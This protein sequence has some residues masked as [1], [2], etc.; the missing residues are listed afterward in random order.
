MPQLMPGA[1]LVPGLDEGALDDLA[2]QIAVADHTRD[3]VVQAVE[4]LLVQASERSSPSSGCRVHLVVRSTLFNISRRECQAAASVAY[5]DPRRE[6]L[7]SPSERWRPRRGRPRNGRP[8][9]R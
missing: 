3:E 1:K 7:R 9:R 8:R 6:M 2:G 5:S 4:M